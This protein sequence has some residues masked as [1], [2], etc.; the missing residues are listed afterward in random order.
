[1]T[2]QRIPKRFDFRYKEAR[3][4]G[5]SRQ[6][7]MDAIRIEN[8]LMLLLQQECVLIQDYNIQM[9]QYLELQLTCDIMRRRLNAMKKQRKR[10][11]RM[12]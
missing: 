12:L 5:Q 1:M 4:S 3:L 9:L 6:L 7:R 8:E 11:S 10:L 2:G